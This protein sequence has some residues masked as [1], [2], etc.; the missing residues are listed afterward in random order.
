MK[1][2]FYPLLAVVILISSAFMSVTTATEWKIKDDYSI[3]FISA[4]PTG[5]FK[6]FG[7]SIKFDEADLAGSKFDLS[8]DVNS[9]STGNGMQNKKALT[10][11]WFDAT[12]FPKITYTSSKIEK[13]GGSYMITGNLKMKGTTKAYKIPFEFKKNGENAKFTGTFNVKRSDFKIGK[14]GG[15][16]PD[17]MKIE[18][19]VPVEKK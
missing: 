14:P 13:V 7:G 16:V 18:F 8:I 9:I 5:I 12:K 11:E 15:A 3:K 19:A 6:T 10:A 17:I 4:D 2:V 1:K